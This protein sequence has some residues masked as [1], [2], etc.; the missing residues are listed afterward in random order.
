[1]K[2]CVLCDDGCIWNWREDEGLGELK[3]SELGTE[4]TVLPLAT[5]LVLN[6]SLTPLLDSP[7][8]R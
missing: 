5:T 1:M 3:T 8:L 2:G 7:I 4:I 6:V